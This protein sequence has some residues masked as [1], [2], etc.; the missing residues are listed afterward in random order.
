VGKAATSHL[1]FASVEIPGQPLKHLHEVVHLAKE[2][3]RRS[4]SFWTMKTWPSCEGKKRGDDERNNTP[5]A[6]Q[7]W[8]TTYLS[9][10]Q[11]KPPRRKTFPGES[12]TALLVQ[13]R[14]LQAAYG[15]DLTP[16]LSETTSDM[17]NVQR[18]ER[19]APV[20]I[21]IVSGE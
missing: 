8:R 21:F 14:W 20:V 9:A 13:R 2:C 10:I 6:I 11:Y 3:D 18:N 5:S 19:A 7:Y 4:K 12:S 15:I 17:R 16:L 1:G